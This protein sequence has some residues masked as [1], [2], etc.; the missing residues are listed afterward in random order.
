M[1]MNQSTRDPRES[2]GIL[3]LYDKT[4]MEIQI[5]GNGNKGHGN[6]KMILFANLVTHVLYNL[7]IQESRYITLWS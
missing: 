7:S 6:G 3:G 4:G 1:G 5:S 2:D